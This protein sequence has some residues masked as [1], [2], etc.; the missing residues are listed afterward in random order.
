MKKNKY[1]H[2]GFTLTELVIVL[3]IIVILAA[4]AIPKLLSIAKYANKAL[5]DNAI[6]SIKSAVSIFESATVLSKKSNNEIV[7]FSNVYG[8]NY[9]PYAHNFKGLIDKGQMTGE[10]QSSHYFGE[11]EIFKAAGLDV[12]DWSYTFL[13]TKKSYAVIATP[14]N[15]LP[16]FPPTAT[17]IR[18]T[19]CYVEYEWKSEGY[20]YIN[21]KTNGCAR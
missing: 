11:P 5:V 21:A 14:K 9:Q 13:D 16:A 19:E 20:P 4:I 2:K 8:I 3:S 10:D 1:K 18:E 6:S 7:S 12:E 17:Q 15:I